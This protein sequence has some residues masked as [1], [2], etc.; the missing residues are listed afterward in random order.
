MKTI[1]NTNTMNANLQALQALVS[2]PGDTILE[3]IEFMGMSQV[4]LA[5]RMGRPKEKINELI[6]GKS[7]ISTETAF[8][9]ERV[10]G[11]P[12]SFWMNREREYRKE[13]YEIEMQEQL[14]LH[15]D[16]LS[17]F[18]LKEMKKFGWVEDSK[19]KSE[20]V[21]QLLHFFGVATTEEWR[22]IYVANVVTVAFRI[23]LANTKSP[24]AL[25]AWLRQ[26]ELESRKLTIADYDKLKFKNALVEIR[27]LVNKFPVDFD[28]QLQS[29]CA[30]CGVAVAYVPTLP[31]APVS[32]ASRWF[33]GKPLIQLSGRYKTDD[34]FWFTF[35]HEAAHILLHG[36]KDIFLENV[37]GT[38][39]DRAKEDEA[40]AF[41][42]EAL[43]SEKE[44]AEILGAE[45]WTYDSIKAFAKKFNTSTGV[46]IGRLQRDKR[47]DWSA[48]ND[49]R[50][51]LDL[52]A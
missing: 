6:K 18:P 1:I 48:G 16:W 34:H 20:L 14:V 46:I 27:S 2:P 24:H 42:A 25:S 10:L 36:K 39:L 43:L 49:L 9:L 23:S 51:K 38:A 21:R 15:Y 31:K 17:C 3:T 50:K 7:P 12:V 22:K 28:T 41:A 8:H 33:H 32:G 47:I 29:L 26:G 4:E 35:Y 13:L 19:D 45:Q 30:S 11:T 52:F 40:N 37:E 5:E 44:Y